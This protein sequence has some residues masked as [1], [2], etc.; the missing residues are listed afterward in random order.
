MRELIGRLR[1]RMAVGAA[2][3]VLL[4]GGAALASFAGGTSPKAEPRAKASTAPTVPA[5]IHETLPGG[6]Q[7]VQKWSLASSGKLLRVYSARRDLSDYSEMRLVPPGKGER[8]GDAY[9][10]QQIQLTGKPV[11]TKPTLLLCWRTTARKSVYTVLVDTTKKPSAIES[12]AQLD[13]AW[14]K[15]S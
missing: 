13:A 2:V 1:G 7:V 14:K 8:Q 5:D 12:V 10:T 9:C 11:E 6:V 15:L 3:A 4:G